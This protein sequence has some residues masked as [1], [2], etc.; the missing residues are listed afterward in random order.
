MKMRELLQHLQKQVEELKKERAKRR[1]PG[2][3]RKRRARS[4]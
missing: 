2:G 1:P 3:V 4:A